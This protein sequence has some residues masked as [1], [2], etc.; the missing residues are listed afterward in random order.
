MPRK[1]ERRREDRLEGSGECLGVRS[2]DGGNGADMNVERG[3]RWQLEVW[4]DFD[5]PDTDARAFV[6][7]KPNLAEPSTL[8]SPS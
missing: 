4:P 6:S 7:P 2:R 5:G 8:S 3:L 1:K